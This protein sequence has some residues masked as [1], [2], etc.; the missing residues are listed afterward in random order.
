MKL[1]KPAGDNN[2]QCCCLYQRVQNVLSLHMSHIM[3]Q[4]TKYLTINNLFKIFLTK[5][6]NLLPQIS[7]AIILVMKSR[8]VKS[9]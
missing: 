1:N 5:T 9:L 2:T 7:V 4:D 6:Y 3:V 8:F